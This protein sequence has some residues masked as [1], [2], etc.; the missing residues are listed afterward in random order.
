MGIFGFIFIFAS[1]IT[2]SIKFTMF[3]QICCNAFGALSYILLGGFSGSGIFFIAMLQSI[4]FFILRM[5]EIKEPKWLQYVVFAAYLL[6]SALTFKG[7]LDIF[8]AI[9]AMLC[10][11]SLVQKKTSYYRIFIFFNGLVWMAYD[12]MISAYSMLASHIFTS[13]SAL[14]GIILWDILKKSEKKKEG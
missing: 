8:P 12:L 11:V 6:C 4:I 14:L 5:K 13:A 7:A 3:C 9:A 10:A 2:K 1:T